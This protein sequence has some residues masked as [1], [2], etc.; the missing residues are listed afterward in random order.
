MTETDGDLLDKVKRL[1][2]LR[3]KRP[4]A[5]LCAACHG[6]GHKAKERRGFGAAVEFENEPCPKCC[7]D[8]VPGQ[9][10]NPAI[11]ATEDTD[12]LGF[13]A[14][15]IAELWPEAV[16]W[17]PSDPTDRMSTPQPQAVMG[18]ELVT[19]ALATVQKLLEKV[20]VLEE[21]VA[22]LLEPKK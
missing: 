18:Y 5:S 20:E 17:E 8:G 2:P 10:N 19:I 3:F 21:S 11:D 14:E 13:A 1:K 15:D 16:A 9:I 12:F 7:G 6:K 22:S 4:H